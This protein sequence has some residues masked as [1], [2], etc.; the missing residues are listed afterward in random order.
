MKL[1][2]LKPIKRPTRLRVWLSK[3]SAKLAGRYVKDCH[4]SFMKYIEK[5]NILTAS[6]WFNAQQKRLKKIMKLINSDAYRKFFYKAI[7]YNPGEKEVLVKKWYVDIFDK[8]VY[9]L[10][11]AYVFVFE[12]ELYKKIKYFET[13]SS[14][15]ANLSARVDKYIASTTYEERLSRMAVTGVISQQSFQDDFDVL[16][17][18]V[19]PETIEAR[20]REKGE[21]TAAMI[22]AELKRKLPDDVVQLIRNAQK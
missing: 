18:R 4:P 11:K 14:G 2:K 5:N 22:Q 1:G 8:I 17:R 9:T 7:S 12:R 21:V 19:S 10:S 16:I 13:V 6:I 3:I 20:Y 15:V